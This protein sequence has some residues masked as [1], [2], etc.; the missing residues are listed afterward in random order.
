MK[1]LI[2]HI[3]LILGLLAF[4]I[5]T[6]GVFLPILPTVPFYLLSVFLVS[7]SSK[8][9]TEWITSTKVYKTHISSIKGNREMRLK[10]KLKLIFFLS[11]VFGVAFLFSTHLHLRIVILVVWMIHILYFAFV[12][13]TKKPDISYEESKNYDK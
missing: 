4:G 5:G 7:R 2:R 12:T 8:R 11:L 9:M 1:S 6:I 10:E 13:K 3:Y